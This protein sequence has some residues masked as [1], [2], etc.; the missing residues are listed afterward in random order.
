MSK[1]ININKAMN[2]GLDD[3]LPFSGKKRTVTTE[4]TQYSWNT[5]VS[6][7]HQAQSVES[8]ARRNWLRFAAAAAVVFFSVFIYQK[9][10]RPATPALQTIATGYGETRRIKLPDQTVVILNSNSSLTIPTNWN[11]QNSRKVWLSGEGYF[12][13]TKSNL[14]GMANFIVQTATMQV[15]V[16]GTKFNVNAYSNQPTVALKEGS[17]EVTYNEQSEKKMVTIA[18][19]ELVKLNVSEKSTPTQILPIETTHVAD[20]TD[21]AFHFDHTTLVEIGE[22][23][24]NRYGYEV[25]IEDENLRKRNIDGHLHA[26]NLEELITALEVTFNITIQKNEN[27][28]RLLVLP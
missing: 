12:E 3:Q 11:N 25:I 9:L 14:P 21:N 19:G 18:P 7:L 4:Q 22:M 16:L 2:E 10:M 28:K 5:I 13:V 1:A 20:W 6:K 27:N 17:V 15:K 23:I 8:L 24:K 26:S